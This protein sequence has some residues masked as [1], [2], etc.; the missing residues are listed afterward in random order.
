MT[1]K[2]S[3]D[4]HKTMTTTDLLTVKLHLRLI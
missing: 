2:V 3:V 4:H 1:I